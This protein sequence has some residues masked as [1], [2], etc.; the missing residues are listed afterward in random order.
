M[1]RHS[2]A[3]MRQPESGLRNPGFIV[4]C[5]LCFAFASMAASAAP[6]VVHVAPDGTGDG[7]SWANAAG[8][9]VA[10]YADAA[11]FAESGCDSGE[12]WMKA[13][14]YVLTEAI[15]LMSGVAVRGGFAGTETSADAA[16]PAANQTIVS[17]DVSGNNKWYV[18]GGSGLSGTPMWQNG[19]F[20]EP[21][22]DGRD[23]YWH[24]NNS[25]CLANETT[26]AFVL[27]ESGPLS[28]AAFSG[29][30][31]TGFKSFVFQLQSA[32]AGGAISFSDC[33]FLGVS[34]G[35]Q[36]GGYPQGSSTIFTYGA[37]ILSYNV[38]V[39]L[40]RC[41]FAGTTRPLFLNFNIAHEIGATNVIQSCSFRANRYHCIYYGVDTTAKA[42]HALLVNDT[43]FARNHSA[44]YS[45]GAVVL[46]PATA[47]N[48]GATV[49]FTDC[50]FEGNI[51]KNGTGGIL[52]F[53][54]DGVKNNVVR[55]RFARN[56]ARESS[57]SWISVPGIYSTRGN[58][59]IRDS[60]FVGNIYTNSSKESAL[61]Y[62]PTAVA[63]EV[64]TCDIV[65]CTF[66]GNRAFGANTN[67]CQSTVY[68][69]S[70]AHLAVANCTFADSVFEGKHKVA[71]E[72]LLQ[73]GWSATGG[74]INTV[75][76]N[77]A[78]DYATVSTTLATIPGK[79]AIGHSV[80]PDYGETLTNQFETFRDRGGITTN[81]APL[82]AR[83]RRKGDLL[84]G[85]GVSAYAPLLW[86]GVEVKI[87]GRRIYAYQPKVNASSPWNR[88]GEDTQVKSISSNPIPDV[89]GTKRC[90]GRI[91]YGPVQPDTVTRLAVR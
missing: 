70:Y 45:S 61:R 46:K 34:I 60:H 42:S 49:S 50:I 90:A 40:D 32:V 20:T 10:A 53:T 11:D 25:S 71:A 63:H 82:A 88:L 8:S 33:K 85:R 21:N 12:V 3:D 86:N 27:A 39:A 75:F 69:A 29:I 51:L 1:L 6:K 91:A 72:I 78:P 62:S 59:L 26:N 37:A 76:D 18:V 81:G 24:G 17:G 44:D 28:G 55:C 65:N 80:L 58:T 15:P 74:I 87:S 77:D 41:E 14:T 4:H 38:A 2:T 7:S 48:C 23:D 47:A 16:D 84:Y 43:T 9:L 56:V 79:F 64:G 54:G 35:G 67:A 52:R 89:F 22:P 31:F 57:G 73:F 13:G 68:G 19:V 66:E 30:T 5:A 36:A 83:G